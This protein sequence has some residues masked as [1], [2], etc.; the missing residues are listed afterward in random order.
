[1]NNIIKSLNL[2]EGSVL[3]LEK[4]NDRIE[5]ESFVIM[6]GTRPICEPD[7]WC[8]IDVHCTVCLDED[9]HPRYVA[10]SPYTTCPDNDCRPVSTY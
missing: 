7:D 5:F 9:C 2:T 3:T 8:G 1:M 4:L 6:K 10:C